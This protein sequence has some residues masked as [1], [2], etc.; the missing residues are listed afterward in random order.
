MR[1]ATVTEAREDLLN[2]VSNEETVTVTKKGHPAVVIVPFEDYQELASLKDAM[3]DPDELF[4]AI[5]SHRLVQQGIR[6]D[7]RTA[8]TSKTEEMISDLEK[9]VIEKTLGIQE[10]IRELQVSV[11][12]IGQTSQ[13]ER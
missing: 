6:S 10:E 7:R 2:I 4:R 11:Q 13:L 9:L 12:R 1:Y 3:R 5:Q 8:A